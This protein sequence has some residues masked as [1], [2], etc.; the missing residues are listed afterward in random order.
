M[1]YLLGLILTFSMAHAII[2]IVPVKLGKKPGVSGA[3]Q[4][5][6]ERKKGNTD[7]NYYSG[8]VRLQY[9]NNSSYVLWSDITGSYGEA[10]GEENANKTYVHIRYIHKLYEKSINWETFVQSETNKYT[11]VDE[12]YLVGGG[13]RYNFLEQDYGDVFVGVGGFNEKITYTTTQDPSETNFRLN[14]YLAYTLKFGDDSKLAYVL[15]YQPN[16]E[17]FSDYIMSNAFGLKIHVYKQLFLSFMLYY[18]EDSE[19]AIG[20]KEYDYTQKTSFIW[21]F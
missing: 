9:D 14:T 20:V 6:S 13:L 8:G 17:D 12:K 3:I 19:P 2:T 7:T 1:K 21:E 10:N 15:Y 18:D 4:G 11:K 16:S 5:S